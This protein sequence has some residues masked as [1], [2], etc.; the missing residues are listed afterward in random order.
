MNVVIAPHSKIIQVIS[1]WLIHQLINCIYIFICSLSFQISDQWTI[2]I[3]RQDKWY[4]TDHTS[5]E[6]T[7]VAIE[8]GVH[9]QVGRGKGR[10]GGKDDEKLIEW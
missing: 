9:W 6:N 5:E 7:C 10:E 2:D 3:W 8:R 4:P 1:F